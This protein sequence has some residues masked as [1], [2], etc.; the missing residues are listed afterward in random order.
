MIII[1]NEENIINSY[2]KCLPMH[3]LIVTIFV[4]LAI[5]AVAIPILLALLIKTNSATA[6]T[7]YNCEI[8]FFFFTDVVN[9][10]IQRS[11][12]KA[13]FIKNS[14]FSIKIF[15]SKSESGFITTAT[16][17]FERHC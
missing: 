4:I 15:L 13:F 9:F 11:S 3:G 17:F 16:G 12:L 10:S 5:S 14:F 2:Y 6:T 1:A 8:L 7:N